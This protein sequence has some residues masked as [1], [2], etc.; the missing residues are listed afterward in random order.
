MYFGNYRI[1]KT[2]L[3]KCLKNPPSECPSANNMVNGNEHCCNLDDGTFIISID[4][5]EH[6]SVGKSLC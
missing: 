6:N 2:G 5:S 1:G 3:D 4:H